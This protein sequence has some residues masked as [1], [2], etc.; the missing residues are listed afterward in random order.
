MTLHAHLTLAFLLLLTAALSLGIGDAPLTIQQMLHGLFGGGDPMATLIMQEIR[1]PRTVL[2]MLVGASLGLSGAALQG[3][4]RNPLAEPG[5]LGISN[6][7]A[8]GAVIA[9]YTGFSAQFALALPVAGIIGACLMVCLLYGLLGREAKTEHLI[10]AGVA[11]SSLAGSLIAVAL[12]LSPNPYAAM[13]IIF[14][15]MGSLEARSMAHVQL[16][17]PF[18]L[19]GGL[20]LLTCG[21]GLEALSLGEDTAVSLGISLKKLQLSVIAGTALVVGP[22]V[23]ITGSIGFVGLMVPH[24]LRPFVQH[25]PRLLLVASALGGSVLLTLADIIVRL[26]PTSGMELK[27]GVVTALIGV[28]FF[29]HLILS[30]RWAGR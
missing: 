24:M 23:A 26:V 3:F 11:L 13:E 7:A 4:L 30:K 1:L 17:L 20:L 22:S 27:L 6:G 9:F 28:P 5:I 16:V 14:W 19:A 25:S 18:L 2:A 29:F 8:L 10:L 21:R 15:L 12:N